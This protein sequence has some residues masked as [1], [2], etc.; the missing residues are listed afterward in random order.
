MTADQFGDENEHVCEQLRRNRLLRSTSKPDSRRAPRTAPGMDSTK[1]RL[2]DLRVVRVALGGTPNH[3]S[4]ERTQVG[5][6]ICK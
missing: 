1:R 6:L 2:P 3:F 4:I 5:R